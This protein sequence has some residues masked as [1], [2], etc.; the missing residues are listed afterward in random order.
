MKFYNFDKF[1]PIDTFLSI[2]KINIPLK[3]PHLLALGHIYGIQIPI[4]M[5]YVMLG[6]LYSFVEGIGEQPWY[7]ASMFMFE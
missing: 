5:I 1:W 3:V 2:T 7:I 4:A 6:S